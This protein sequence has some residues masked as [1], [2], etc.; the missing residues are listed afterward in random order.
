MTYLRGGPLLGAK[1]LR[2]LRALPSLLSYLY[3]LAADLQH[4]HRC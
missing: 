2:T 4:P 3:G 1:E